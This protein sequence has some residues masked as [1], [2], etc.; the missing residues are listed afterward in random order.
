M[1]QCLESHYRQHGGE[2]LDRFR[3][4]PDITLGRKKR[5]DSQPLS[6]DFPH[7][8][9][10]KFFDRSDFSWLD[11]IEAATD[12]IRDEFPEALQMEAGFAPYTTYPI[13][14]PRNQWVE[15]GN[16]SSRARGYRARRGCSTTPSNM[17]RGMTVASCALR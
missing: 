6:Y 4:S 15:F 8:P 7:L 2:K 17:R 1:D 9:P 13:G 11:S 3:D 14:V 5:F 16:V 12:D 10:I